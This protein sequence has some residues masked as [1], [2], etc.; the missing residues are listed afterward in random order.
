LAECRDGATAAR[1][2]REAAPDLVFLDVQL[3]GM[4]GLDVVAEVEAEHD[5][6]VVLMAP[7]EEYA[8]Q[9]FEAHA[10]DYLVKPVSKRRCRAA[11]THVKNHLVQQD[12][13]ALAED[14]VVR[15]REG[16]SDSKIRAHGTRTHHLQQ[17]LVKSGGRTLL[18]DAAAIDWVGAT[19]DYVMLHAGKRHIKVRH[20]MGEME[21]KLD[22]RQFIRIHRS[23]IVNVARV[24][25]LEPY[26]HGEY[27]VVL[28]DGTKLRLA[29]RRR[30]QFEQ[31]LGQSL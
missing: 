28:Q 6:A 8:L 30:E 29:R 31:L 24:K 1:A 17:I 4:S 19:G 2:I 26:F 21:R 23:A 20:T 12:M 9:A 5:V 15:L 18:V 3:L 16:G 14:L 7:S 11:L 13:A 25:E 22:P 27:V 10:L